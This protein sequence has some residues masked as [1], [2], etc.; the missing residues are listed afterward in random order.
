MATDPYALAEKQLNQI[1]MTSICRLLFDLSNV[2]E[3]AGLE[4][5][6]EMG[7]PVSA[8]HLNVVPHIDIGGTRLT[9]LAQRAH[10]TK[11]SAWESLKNMEAQGYIERTKDPSDAR[12]V[13]ISWTPKGMDFLRVVCHGLLIREDDMAKRIGRK[14]A[15]ILKELLAKLRQSYARQ[16]PDMRR[17]VASLGAE[18]RR[19]RAGGKRPKR[20]PRRRL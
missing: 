2:D 9:E 19:K 3:Y 7:Y 6:K 8:A 10:L 1:Y 14:E 5:L 16:P 20:R 11:Q 15:K 18:R 12:A 4:M 17:F 13:L